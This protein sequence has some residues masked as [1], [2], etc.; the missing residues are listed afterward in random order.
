MDII[1]I[2]GLKFKMSELISNINLNYSS[3]IVDRD[4]IN[5]R[6]INSLDVNQT[7][8][9]ILVTEPYDDDGTIGGDVVIYPPSPQ[10]NI[11]PTIRMNF[12]NGKYLYFPC[13]AKYDHSRGKIWILDTGNHRIIRL[14]ENTQKVNFILNNVIFYPHAIA[15]NLN[16][17]GSFV[18]GFSN[19]S[20]TNGKVI[21]I[22]PVGQLLGYFEYDEGEE[23][24]SSSTSS[25][26]LS[27]S[28]DSEGNSSS[29]SSHDYFP[30][31][32]SYKSIVYDSVRSRAWWVSGINVYMLD[33]RNMQIK[34]FNMYSNFSEI[35]N[36]DIEFSTGNAFVV[37][38]DSINDTYVIQVSKDNSEVLGIAYLRD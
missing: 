14:D 19:S 11:D 31:M 5:D 33:E 27:E 3:T 13:D 4:L 38:K 24:N 34:V 18:K 8:G 9:K 2:L 6:V 17:G 36:I 25:F 1:F 22:S 15:P 30:T 29:S 12:F 21:S 23:D 10:L 28:S 20:M 16:T 37:V 35:M 32:P 26:S 7:N